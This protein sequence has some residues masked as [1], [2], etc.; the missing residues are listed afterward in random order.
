MADDGG[1]GNNEQHFFSFVYLQNFIPVGFIFG[2]MLKAS[3]IGKIDPGNNYI[4]NYLNVTIS[5]YITLLLMA[6]T[7]SCWFT[8]IAYAYLRLVQFFLRI[9]INITNLAGIGPELLAV[10]QVNTVIDQLIGVKF[11]YL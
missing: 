3:Y 5:N 10:V 2:L 6:C 7:I 8:I 11:M 4:P 9:I 1:M